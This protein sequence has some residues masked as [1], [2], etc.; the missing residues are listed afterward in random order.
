M[1]KS[2]SKI[3]LFLKILKKNSKGLHNIQSSVMLLDLHDKID[4]KK[5][6]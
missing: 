5:N 2:Y 1:I 6:K 3:N 4:L